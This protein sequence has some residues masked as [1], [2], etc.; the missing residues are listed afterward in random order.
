LGYIEFMD[1][2]FI[3]G[4]A[5]YV[6]QL[7]AHE[8]AHFLWHNVLATETQDEFLALSGWSQT[9]SIET[10]T[11]SEVASADH[12]KAASALGADAW[13]RTT[14]TNFVSDY[15]AALNPDEDFAETVAYY[16]YAPDKV[17]GTA[18]EK[19]AF[20]NGV[21]DGYEYVTLVEEQFT[22]QVFNLEPDFTY[23]G[24]IVAI[25]T[26]V[27]KSVNGDNL[28]TATLHLSPAYGD[29]ASEALARLFSPADTFIDLRFYPVD[30][31][32]F[33]LQTTFNLG[34]YRAAGYWRLGSVTVEDAV[35]N[36]RFEGQD[37]FGWQLY[38]DNP[39][40]DLEPPVA[41]LDGITSRVVTADGEQAVRVIV[42]VSDNRMSNLGGWSTLQQYAS[43]QRLEQ[44]ATYVK[45]SGEIMFTFP[46]RS[47]LA[48]GEWVF[49]E[50]WVFDEAGNEQRYD[51]KEAAPG[52][53]V[54][55]TAPDQTAPEL[56]ITSV[57]IE[58]S[59]RKP[60]APDGETDVT[61]WFTAW[62]D[63]AGIGTV[64]YRLLKPTGDS[65]FDYHYHAN[66][67]TAYFDGDPAER[68][69]YR[70]DLTLPPG[71]PPGTWILSDL[72]IH[73][74]AGNVLISNFVETGILRP[75]E[76]LGEGA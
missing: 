66:F 30:G 64:T 7:I 35:E 39:D 5:T 43:A 67:Y 37:Q 47:Y 26:T 70:I 29:G 33:T 53:L 36:R 57:R 46:M 18:P 50:V 76:V 38:I 20:V 14:T 8:M 21:V 44:Y 4:D 24:K 74:K 45:G 75:I 52:I 11:A 28:V 12:P 73:D 16:V 6:R 61:I 54:T 42:P 1:I 63:S 41:D 15:A 51:L 65:L 58:A 31:D 69:E 55:T 17:R 60:E 25:D 3:S 56:D 71:S 19:Y 13:Y 34:R 9:Q 32:A 49:R 22:F 68:R 10:R 2:A 27:T 48:T 72:V 23:P 62:D 59:P 40:E